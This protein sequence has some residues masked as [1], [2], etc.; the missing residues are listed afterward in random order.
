MKNTRMSIIHSPNIAL[1]Y[2]DSCIRDD[3]A[4]D[5]CMCLA[6]LVCLVLCEP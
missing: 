4:S 6:V 3:A 5:E 2:S 1:H